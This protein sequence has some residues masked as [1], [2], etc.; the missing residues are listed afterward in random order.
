[1]AEQQKVVWLLGSGFS[2]PLGGPLLRDLFRQEREEDIAAFFPK[3]KYPGLAKSLPWVQGCFH[4]GQEEGLWENAEQFLAYVDDGYG[5]PGSQGKK[6]RLQNLIGRTTLPEIEALP[7]LNLPIPAEILEYR[8]NLPTNFD[9]KVKRALASECMSFTLD[10][11][12]DSQAEKWS[13][14]RK[15]AVNLTV[16]TDTVIT[17]NYDRAIDIAVGAVERTNEFWFAG[18]GEPPSAGK[19]P[20]LRLHGSVDWRISGGVAKVPA[21]K[22]L[23]EEEDDVGI[24][25]PGGSKAQFVKQYL[26][27]L[28]ASARQALTDATYLMIVGYSFPETDPSAT[29]DLLDAFANGGEPKR[30]V[31]IVLGPNVNDP[32]VRRVVSL[33]KSTAAGRSIIVSEGNPLDLSTR[34]GDVLNIVLH[35]NYSQDFIGRSRAFLQAHENGH[36]KF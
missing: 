12:C 2:K 20:I 31:H 23:C 24:A 4:L 3:H 36:R 16:G 1:M 27:T 17:F 26:G 14:H 8:R 18:P 11:Q 34:G 15:W 6:T 32:I 33:V 29:S 28:W 21:F 30:Q 7:K 5:F 22:I 25:A 10:D 19:I 35:P 13:S 9:K